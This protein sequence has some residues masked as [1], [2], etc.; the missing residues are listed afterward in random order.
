MLE[1]STP[2]HTE[3]LPSKL[4]SMLPIPGAAA[5]ILSFLWTLGWQWNQNAKSYVQLSLTLNVT[6]P[7]MMERE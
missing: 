7:E 1:L 2:D 3:E 4:R 6:N 5:G